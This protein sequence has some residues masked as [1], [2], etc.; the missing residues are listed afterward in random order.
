M[1][2][3]LTFGDLDRFKGMLIHC[4]S[5][6]RI[7]QYQPGHSGSSPALHHRRSSLTLSPAARRAGT[8]CGPRSRSMTSGNAVTRT[9]SKTKTRIIRDDRARHEKPGGNPM[10]AP[11]SS[12][13]GAT[14]APSHRQ[15]RRPRKFASRS[16]RALRGKAP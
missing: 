8:W 4:L 16:R 12:R 15:R 14:P 10:T 11:S 13:P 3:V 2:H 7:V 1:T 5:C 9:G 6:G